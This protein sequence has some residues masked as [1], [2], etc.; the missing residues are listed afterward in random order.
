MRLFLLMMYAFA[1]VLFVPVPALSQTSPG[2][3]SAAPDDQYGGQDP[4][5]G[6]QAAH[7]AILASGAIQATS[8]EAQAAERNS[9][10]AAEL[11]GAP[12]ERD[13]MFAE[14]GNTEIAGA[15]SASTAGTQGDEKNATETP[16]ESA[17]SASTSDLK[18]L[19]HTGGPSLLWFGIPLVCAGG[20]L[21]RRILL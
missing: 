13:A 16:G 19:P 14:Q 4:D 5:V 12:S 8:E 2:A 11:T 6:D 17:E 7:D 9:V 18:K 10:S 3:S 1:W 20:F 21:A 15:Q